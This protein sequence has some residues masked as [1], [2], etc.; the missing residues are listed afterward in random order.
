MRERRRLPATGVEVEQPWVTLR[1]DRGEFYPLEACGQLVGV[2]WRG[3]GEVDVRD[4][5]PERA[6]LLH[7][8]FEN[9]PGS[10]LLEGAL[11]VASDG[12]LEK[13]LAD[14]EAGLDSKAAAQMPAAEGDAPWR[15][16]SIPVGVRQ[17][18]LARM[19]P[20]EPIK[21]KAGAH[22]PGELMFAPGSALGGSWL[23]LNVAGAKRVFKGGQLVEPLRWLTAIH[24]DEAGFRSVERTVLMERAAGPTERSWIAA[25]P[26]PATMADAGD[27]FGEQ[28]RRKRFDIRS[29]EAQVFFD[30]TYGADHDLK[31]VQVAAALTLVAEEEAG[32]IVPLWLAEGR[33]RVLGEQWAEVKVKSVHVDGQGVRFDRVADRLF[34]H[35][36]APPAEGSELRIDVR[37]GG[38]LVEPVGQTAISALVGWDWYPSNSV[39]DRHEFTSVVTVP[40]FWKVVS[41]G[42]RIEEM[43]DGRA[44][45]V[46]SRETRPVA[47]G[48]IH[49]VDCRLEVTP[50]PTPDLPVVRILRSPRTVAVTAQ[51][52]DQV[53]AHLEV[54]S[55]ILGPFPYK[56]LE[57]VERYTGGA[58][59][60]PGVIVVPTF[61][62]P[63]DQVVTTAAGGGTLLRALAQQYLVSD[64]G[65]RSYH[66]DWLIAGLGLLAECEALEAAGKPGR[67]VGHARGLRD[68]WINF[69]RSRDASWLIGPIWLGGFSGSGANAGWRG[70][71]V[72]YQLRLML[73]PDRTRT[74]MTRIATSYRGQGLSTR[75]FVL[76]AQAVAGVDLRAFFYGWV[77]ATPQ[78]PVVFAEW[79][80]HQQAD[81]T[82]TLAIS[83]HIDAERD[84]DPLPMLA[85]LLVRMKVDD[86]DAWQLVVFTQERGDY[87]IAGIPAEP[88]KVGLETST[89]PGKVELTKAP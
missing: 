18:V 55:R 59:T 20:F 29:V 4:P 72:L 7:D 17:M 31:D 61:D 3:E 57:I 66:D 89:F 1:L 11:I 12:T 78:Q 35:L 65:G 84:G 15:E 81:G 63:P 58:Y 53:H 19:A 71:L 52:A 36:P 74:L 67:C 64:M 87:T 76:H 16:T 6:H 32:A 2:A 10:L 56:E 77:F 60:G 24:S 13:L 41:T 28:A 75:S 27:P 37:Y 47:Q 26:D 33:R 14:A 73:G 5:G 86:Q 70:P 44:R 30:P 79:S 38:A 83:G 48:H 49:V 50:P 88:K 39:E 80:T 54:L 69:M 40:A 51:F 8:R 43:E 34:V 68:S 21:G 9:L 22:P 23:D 82:W 42:R 85:P 45:I 25:I 62:S 46:T